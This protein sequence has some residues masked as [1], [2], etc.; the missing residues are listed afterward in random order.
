MFGYIVLQTADYCDLGLDV[1]GGRDGLVTGFARM[2]RDASGVAEPFLA[3]V[4][5]EES[6]DYWLEQRWLGVQLNRIG[7]VCVVVRPED[8]LFDDEEGVFV[9]L[10]AA[11]PSAGAAHRSVPPSPSPVQSTV[12]SP[13]STDV[14]RAW[15]APGM[16]SV[17]RGCLVS[18]EGGGGGEEGAVSFVVCVAVW[19]ARLL[20]PSLCVS[21]PFV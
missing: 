6:N 15:Q 11:S 19:R 16:H 13:S 17:R 5:S 1:L 2:I 7:L 8:L 3:I 21:A 10:V 18:G 12:A 20:T 4:V 14:P 9:K